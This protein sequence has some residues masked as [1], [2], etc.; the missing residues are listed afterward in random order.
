MSAIDL[1]KPRSS[2]MK[3]FALT[4]LSILCLSLA[5]TTAI[6]A[7][8]RTAQISKLTPTTIDNDASTKITPFELVSRAYQGSFKSQGIPSF[9]AFLTDTS[10]KTLVAKDLIK[11]A[12]DA[13]QLAPEAQF[14]LNY[15][16]DINSYLGEQ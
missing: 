6:E 4:S 8:P 14:D 16:S 2:I 5:T 3:R 7:A 1:E 11:A 10:N 12:I 15:I 13:K 9:G